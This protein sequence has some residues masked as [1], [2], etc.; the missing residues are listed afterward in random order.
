VL[1]S[2]HAGI[3][4]PSAIHFKSVVGVDPDAESGDSAYST[5]ANAD[6]WASRP[7][8][9]RGGLHFGQFGQIGQV[10]RKL[11]N[12]NNLSNLN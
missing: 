6:G 1:T 8:Q 11:S 7:C 10:I 4:N 2:V 12:L 3:F 5:K 9:R